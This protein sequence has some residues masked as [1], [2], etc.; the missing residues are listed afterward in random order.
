M[1]T[2]AVRV[3]LKRE[4]ETGRQ[5]EPPPWIRER[6][7]ESFISSDLTPLWSSP[8]LG[9]PYLLSSPR[10]A[11]SAIRGALPGV[12]DGSRDWECRVSRYF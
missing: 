12:R 6:S 10:S 8:Q 11:S 7:G 3:L 1:L 4:M 9:T 2:V 5:V